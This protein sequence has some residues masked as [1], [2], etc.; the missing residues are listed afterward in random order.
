MAGTATAVSGAVTR[1]GD[2]RAQQ[3]AEAQAREQQPSAPP[4][5]PAPAPAAPAPAPDAGAD[6]V[7]QLKQLA[8]LKDRGA[9]TDAE[10]QAQKARILQM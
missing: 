8:D 9:L 3:Q 2:A 7:G 1:H 10:F 4:A 5:A 6:V